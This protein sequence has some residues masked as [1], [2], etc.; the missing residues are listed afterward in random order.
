M[1]RPQLC[2]RRALANLPKGPTHRIPARRCAERMRRDASPWQGAIS[3][4]IRPCV[5]HMLEASLQHG[6]NTG[7]HRVKV[8]AI[9]RVC[10]VRG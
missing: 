9:R 8:K 6:G 4:C 5:T 10:H 2:L 7:T 1:L 3:R